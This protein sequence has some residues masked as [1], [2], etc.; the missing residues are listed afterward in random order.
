MSERRTGVIRWFTGAKGFGFVVEDGDDE[1][2][3]LHFSAIQAPGY[4]CLTEGQRVVFARAEGSRG[5]IARDV[6]PII[7]D[8][9]ESAE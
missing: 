8:K 9:D 3:F 7:S 5:P 1:D 2:L 4:K 6:V